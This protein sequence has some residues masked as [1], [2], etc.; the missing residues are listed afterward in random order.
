M[1]RTIALARRIETLDM[2]RTIIVSTC[3]IAMIVAE[4]FVPFG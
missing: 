2:A 3:A 4:R 1:A